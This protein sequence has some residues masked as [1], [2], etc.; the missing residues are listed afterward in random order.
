MTGREWAIVIAIPVSKLSSQSHRIRLVPF[1]PIRAVSFRFVSHGLVR[2]APSRPADV[3]PRRTPTMRNSLMYKMSYYRF[4]ELFGGH[5]AQD[6]V[7]GQGL[8]KT[9]PTLDTLGEWFD[10]LHGPSIHRIGSSAVVVGRWVLRFS[11]V[12]EF[13]GSSLTPVPVPDEAFTSENWIVRI[14]EVKKEDP[15]GREHKAVTAFEAGKRLKRSKSAGS[16]KKS[17]PSM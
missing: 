9:G 16:G 3:N 15:I 14:Y 4:A 6:R 7:R 5:P 10:L 17:R 8:P 11:G 2:L 13:V 1:A 12:V